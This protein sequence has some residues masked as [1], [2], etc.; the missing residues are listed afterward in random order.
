MECN[1]DTL[2]NYL[3]ENANDRASTMAA[4]CFLALVLAGRHIWGQE[5]SRL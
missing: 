2:R 1:P 4:S 5:W 3:V